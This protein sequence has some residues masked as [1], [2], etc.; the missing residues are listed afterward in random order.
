MPIS[1][2]YLTGPTLANLSGY[3]EDPFPSLPRATA[4]QQKSQST[5]P[6]K[7]TQQET[8]TPAAQQPL[9]LDKQIQL[10]Q[11]K[12][13]NLQ[14]QLELTRAQP[15]SQEVFAEGG[16]VPT[17]KHLRTKDKK[18]RKHLS[19]LPNDYLFSAKGKIDYDNL[20][21][22]EF[23]G[24]FL[25]FLNSQSEFAQQ[26]YLAYLKLLMESA[27]TYSWNSVRNFYFSINTAVEAG[28]LSLQQFDQIK[29]RAQTFFTHAD[30]PSA[31]TTPRVS[32]TSSQARYSKKD[33]YCKEWN[34]TGKCINCSPTEATYKGIHRCRV[35]DARHA[36]LQCAKCR[37]PIPNTFS[38]TPKSED[39]H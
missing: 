33:T 28:R 21:I 35:C 25:E 9:S 39:K 8:T 30:L 11:L 2:D 3:L 23:V 32:T 12:H 20:E 1:D 38:G 19:L 22:S 17:L 18:E 5:K 37:F 16:S 10:E 15:P 27:A 6:G 7:S 31:P 34:Y 36:M 29:D 4:D 26:R 13:S 14:L 24:G